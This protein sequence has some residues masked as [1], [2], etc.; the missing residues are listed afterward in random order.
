MKRETREPLGK[1]KRKELFPEIPQ[2]KQNEEN[3][4]PTLKRI[5]LKALFS[6]K[7]SEPTTMDTQKIGPTP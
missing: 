5:K 6:E 4:D 7:K 2:N 3:P 1:M